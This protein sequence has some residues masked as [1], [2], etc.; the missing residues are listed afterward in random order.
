MKVSLPLELYEMFV[1]AADF[2]AGI[3]KKSEDIPT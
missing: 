2:M 1:A 3:S